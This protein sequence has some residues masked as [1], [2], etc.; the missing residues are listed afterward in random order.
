LANIHLPQFAASLGPQHESVSPEN[1]ISPPV[2]DPRQAG[3]E[4]TR[5]PDDEQEATAFSGVAGGPGTRRFPGHCRDGGWEPEALTPGGHAI[6]AG[7]QRRKQSK[8]L[9]PGK[10]GT[11]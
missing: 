7:S 6:P 2:P 1:T 8:Q 5:T 4:G 10:P 11:H 9:H 3:K